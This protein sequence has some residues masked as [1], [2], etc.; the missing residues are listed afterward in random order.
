MIVMSTSSLICI[1]L[2]IPLVTPLTLTGSVTVI[3]FS[4]RMPLGQKVRALKEG[5][6][7]AGDHRFFFG[8]LEI[9]P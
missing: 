4:K 5:P 1:I 7:S 3:T 9:L 8:Y 6:Q 2:A